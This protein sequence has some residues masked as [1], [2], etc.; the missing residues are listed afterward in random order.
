MDQ[1]ALVEHIVDRLRGEPELR[2]LFLGGS[3]GRSAGD[4][5]SDVDLIAVVAPEA[6]EGF[7]G[8]WRSVL[9]GITPVV[10]WRTRGTANVLVN[11]ITADWLR[12]DLYVVDPPAVAKRAQSGLTPLIDPA[13]IYATLPRQLPERTPDADRVRYLIEEFLRVLGLLPVVVGREEYVTAVWGAGL[14]R[15]HLIQLMQEDVALADP[16][17]ALHLSRILPPEDMSVLTAL[18]YPRPE[19][20]EVIDAH[21]A[22][23]AAFLPRAKQ[24]AKKLGVAWPEAFAAATFAHVRKELDVELSGVDRAEQ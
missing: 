12:C 7:A 19:R 24:M 6:R 13:G 21:A 17:G 11:A 4:R 14:Q 20:Q 23:A 16:G 5:F 2:A 9:G 3:L 18:P 10:F 8:R 22:L 15:D 1:S